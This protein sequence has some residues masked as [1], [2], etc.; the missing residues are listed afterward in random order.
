[1]KTLNRQVRV[2]TFAPQG[3]PPRRGR[4]L[5]LDLTFGSI[6]LAGAVSGLPTVAHVS[7]ISVQVLVQV[8]RMSFA[9]LQIFGR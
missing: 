9:A 4:R 8:C 3:Q 7:Q 2:I 5:L 6:C 1:M